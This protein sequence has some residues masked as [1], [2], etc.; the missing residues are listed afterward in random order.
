MINDCLIM[1]GSSGTRLWPTSSTRKPKQF[2][3]VVK[4]GIESFFLKLG[5]C[6][7]G[8]IKK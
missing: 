1:A 4:G 5:A 6:N 3:P 2:L 7:M 8:R